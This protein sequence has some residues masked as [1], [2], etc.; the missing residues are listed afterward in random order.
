MAILPQPVWRNGATILGSV[1]AI[2][3]A[4][5]ALSLL[6]FDL[7]SPQRSPYLGIFAYLVFPA[8]FVLGLGVS[9]VGLLLSGW[10]YQRRNLGAIVQYYPRIDLNLRSHRRALL[11]VGGVVARTLPCIGLKDGR[12]VPPGRDAD[13][14]RGWQ[15]AAVIAAIRPAAQLRSHAADAPEPG[16]FG[17][18]GVEPHGA[19]IRC[20]GACRSQ[21][22]RWGFFH[23]IA[24]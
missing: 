12:S 2:L 1:V 23:N 20:P 14:R 3:A 16:P 18:G 13:R 6:F 9:L 22:P 4:L 10:R 11:A 17:P 21:L 8:I 19:V 5:F 15:A 7:V 24:R